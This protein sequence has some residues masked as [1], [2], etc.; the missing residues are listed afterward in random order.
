MTQADLDKIDAAIATGAVVEEMTFADQTFRFRS[1]GDML[2]AR[3]H[4]ASLLLEAEGSAPT[5]RLAATS[6]GV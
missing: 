2:K 6:K 4:I 3:E 5:Y 1:I